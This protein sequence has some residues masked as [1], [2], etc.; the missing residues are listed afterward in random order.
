M[1]KNGRGAFKSSP[2]I[3]PPTLP[4]LFHKLRHFRSH[5]QQLSP[6]RQSGHIQPPTPWR[7]RFGVQNL[8]SCKI[9]H[10]NIYSLQL[11]KWAFDTQN[12]VGAQGWIHFQAFARVFLRYADDFGARLRAVK[13][14]LF[15]AVVKPPGLPKGIFIH[16]LIATR[17]VVALHLPDAVESAAVGAAL[18]VEVAVVHFAC[19]L[20][21]EEI[22]I[23]CTS[24]G[25][26][27]KC[28]IAIRRIK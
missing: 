11:Q 7:E 8:L 23:A 12:A 5:F 24:R 22:V 15:E 4:L 17:L 3:A 6:L 20:P 14:H 16:I 10:L 9:E 13:I 18:D 25:D 2:S 28:I 26:C 27:D 21:S 1:D 19:R